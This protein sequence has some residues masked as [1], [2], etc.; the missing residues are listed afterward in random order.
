MMR[1]K[2]CSVSRAWEA[3]DYHAIKRDGETVAMMD[4]WLHP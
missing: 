4:I 2:N 3:L 1:R